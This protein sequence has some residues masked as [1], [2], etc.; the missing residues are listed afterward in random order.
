MRASEIIGLKWADVYD[1]HVELE[2]TKNGTAR[3]VPLS[4]RAIEILSYM[5]GIDEIDLSTV[6]NKVADGEIGRGGLSAYF[7]QVLKGKLKIKDLTFHDTRH[8]A[9]S[10]LVKTAK[11]PVEVL[12]KITGHK[13]ISI[14]INTY[15]NPDIEELADHLHKEDDPDIIPFKKSI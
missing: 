8:E 10:R 5:H 7:T 6:K 1:K 3:K 12:A 4:K 9:I 14:L 15:Y 2:I 13:T 11:L